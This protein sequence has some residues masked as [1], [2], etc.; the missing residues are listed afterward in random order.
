MPLRVLWRHFHESTG[1]LMTAR[2]EFNI[3]AAGERVL[4]GLRT[5]MNGRTTLLLWRRSRGSTQITTRDCRALL[6]SLIWFRHLS[7][8]QRLELIVDIVWK[9]FRENPPE[10]QLIE[11]DII[12]KDLQSLTKHNLFPFAKRAPRK[13]SFCPARRGTFLEIQKRS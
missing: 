9:H 2:V 4:R 10:K 11:L 13:V 12:R 3:S 7:D 6:Y 1:E 5:A 8:D